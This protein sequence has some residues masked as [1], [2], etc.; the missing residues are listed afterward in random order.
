MTVNL[1]N[2]WLVKSI[3]FEISITS[4]GDSKYQV[5]PRS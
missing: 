2:F 3:I 5:F 4:V 1:P